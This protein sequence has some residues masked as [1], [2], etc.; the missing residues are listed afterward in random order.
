M[1]IKNEK[2]ITLIALIVTI[3]VLIILAGVAI[4]M[5][6]DN[7]SIL[8]NAN[9]VQVLNGKK[10]VVE[11]ESV[12]GI[13]SSDEAGYVNGN[14]T[15]IKNVGYGTLNTY[16]SGGSLEGTTTYDT[17]RVKLIP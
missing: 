10:E 8:G 4:A 5:L 7:N 17:F 9:K 1:K 2:G 11:L 14:V 6:N 3:I 15:G 16:V 13:S 12:D